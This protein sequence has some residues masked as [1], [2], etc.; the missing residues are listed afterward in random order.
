M[1]FFDNEEVGLLPPGCPF[2]HF[3]ADP[4]AHK[5]KSR[6]SRKQTFEQLANSFALSADNGHA[7]H[8]NF[9]EKADPTNRPVLGGNSH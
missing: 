8:P 3:A 4:F 1:H 9:P 2:R 5:F 7:L 6:N